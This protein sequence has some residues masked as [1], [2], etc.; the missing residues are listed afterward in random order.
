MIICFALELVLPCY[1][2]AATEPTALCDQQKPPHE[3]DSADPSEGLCPS[4][5]LPMAPH[6]EPEQGES[7]A[8]ED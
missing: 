7:A 1:T 5:E 4:M 3:L 2:S 8:A 6:G